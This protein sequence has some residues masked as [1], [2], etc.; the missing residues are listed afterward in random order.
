MGLRSGYFPE[1]LLMAVKEG[2]DGRLVRWL[3][4]RMMERG[5]E[6]VEDV[7][8]EEEERSGGNNVLGGRPLVASV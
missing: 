6:D 4:S 8:E 3:K 2:G 7:E 5:V 1:R